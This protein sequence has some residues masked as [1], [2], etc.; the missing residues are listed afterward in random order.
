MDLQMMRARIFRRGDEGDGFRLLRVTHVDDRKAVGKHV[1]DIGMAFFDYDLH[2]VKT[3][4][5]I[6]TRQKADIF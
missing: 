4:A 2:A 1:P 5:L 6:V 3:A